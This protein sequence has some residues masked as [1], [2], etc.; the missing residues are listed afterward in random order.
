[1]CRQN[2]RISLAGND[3][4]WS[5]VFLLFCFFFRRRSSGTRSTREHGICFFLCE[6]RRTNRKRD[7]AFF[8]NSTT[9][10]LT[11]SWL[12]IEIKAFITCTTSILFSARVPSVRCLF[13]SL[14]SGR[15][16]LIRQENH[17]RQQPSNRPIQRNFL[18]WSKDFVFT[19]STTSAGRQNNLYRWH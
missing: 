17:L 14:H 9:I 3:I 11:D 4:T 8:S 12:T 10:W 18:F 19:S 15:N 2:Q 7:D 13:C 6:S 5:P 16:V 1:M